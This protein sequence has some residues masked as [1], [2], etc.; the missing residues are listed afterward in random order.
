MGV[1]FHAGLKYDLEGSGLDE[2]PE[3]SHGV[4]VVYGHHG[5][6]GQVVGGE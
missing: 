6:D 3:A 4:L 5:R 2:A 1:T